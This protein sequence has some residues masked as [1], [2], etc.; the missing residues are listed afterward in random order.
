MYTTAGSVKMQWKTNLAIFFAFILSGVQDN[1][2]IAKSATV[3]SYCRRRVLMPI[4]IRLWHVE[5][6]YDTV[7]VLSLEQVLFFH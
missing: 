7:R 4:L 2:L 5:C 6:C 1:S 3:N